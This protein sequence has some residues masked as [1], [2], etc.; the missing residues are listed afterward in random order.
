[1][2]ML[3]MAVGF[4]GASYSGNTLAEQ[5]IAPNLAGTLLGITNTFGSATGFLA[6]ATVG[7]ITSGNVRPD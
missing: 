5:D 3:C 2:A 7:A 6:P 4:N 1:M